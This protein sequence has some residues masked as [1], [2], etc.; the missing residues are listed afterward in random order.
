MGNIHHAGTVATINSDTNQV[1]GI[2][3]KSGITPSMV[4][5]SGPG[6]GSAWTRDPKDHLDYFKKP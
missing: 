3:S 4:A 6:A 5:P 1:T 2:N